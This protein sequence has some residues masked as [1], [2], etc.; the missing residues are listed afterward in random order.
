LRRPRHGNFGCRA[1]KFSG[2]QPERLS[3]K[4]ASEADHSVDESV[5]LVEEGGWFGI[6]KFLPSERPALAR[7]L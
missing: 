5:Q 2:A 1:R 6:K 4:G 3:E 7:W